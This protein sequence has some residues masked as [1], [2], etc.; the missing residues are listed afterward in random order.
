MSTEIFIILIFVI[1]LVAICA[2][3]ISH[4]SRKI[5]K[6]EDD[7]CILRLKQAANETGIISHTSRLYRL[8]DKIKGK[9][10][11]KPKTPNSELD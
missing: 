6:H 3:V 11:K 5:E 8:E 1:V 4:F 2:I 7:I 10:N 9:K